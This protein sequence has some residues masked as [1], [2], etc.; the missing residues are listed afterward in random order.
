MIEDWGL[1]IKVTAFVL[2]EKRQICSKDGK[3]SYDAVTI[4]FALFADNELSEKVKDT[5][6]TYQRKY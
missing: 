5:V 4:Q 6:K 3:T 1:I 2:S